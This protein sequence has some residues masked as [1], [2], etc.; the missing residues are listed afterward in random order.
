VL[1]QINLPCPAAQLDLLQ[2]PGDNKGVLGFNLIWLYQKWVVL[3]RP[4]AVP[5]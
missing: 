2:L 3:S 1:I 4:Q 5:G